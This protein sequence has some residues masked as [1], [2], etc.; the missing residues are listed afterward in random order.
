MSPPSFFTLNTIIIYFVQVY[1]VD[2][3]FWHHKCFYDRVVHQNCSFP[4]SPPTASSHS[5]KLPQ[6]PLQL[7]HLS[8]RW[9][10]VSRVAVCCLLAWPTKTSMHDLLALPIPPAGGMN[11]LHAWGPYRML[12]GNKWQTPSPESP[13]RGELHTNQETTIM[14][15]T[16]SWNNFL[17]CLYPYTFW[18]VCVH[19]GS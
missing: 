1:S 18:G 4:L 15:F 16:W 9:Q 17:P 7:M 19:S 11:T 6:P 8:S 10:P 13:I 12:W 3:L 2:I 5:W 14:E